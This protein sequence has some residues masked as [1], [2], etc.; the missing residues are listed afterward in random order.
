MVAAAAGTEEVM[1]VEEEEEAEV[2]AGT[3]EEEGAAAAAPSPAA[4]PSKA[5]DPTAA[6]AEDTGV[7]EKVAG[8][9]TGAVVEVDT[10]AAVVGTEAGPAATTC[11]CSSQ[12]R[13]SWW[14]AR[15]ILTAVVAYRTDGQCLR[16]SWT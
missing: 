7:G 12:N 9:A 14:A 6:A 4:T 11:K 8:A 2:A 10:V 3:E 5:R 16:M 13:P 15:Q 1:A